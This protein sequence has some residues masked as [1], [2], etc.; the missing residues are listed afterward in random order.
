MTAL[1]KLFKTKREELCYSQDVVAE[2]AG[3]SR[4]TL[5]NIE[6]GHMPKLHVALGIIR[7]LGIPVSILELKA[8]KEP[9]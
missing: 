6:N 5:I 4:S 7:F 9:G 1:G 3:V 2:F 8:A